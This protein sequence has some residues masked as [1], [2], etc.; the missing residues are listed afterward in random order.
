MLTEFRVVV[1][2]LSDVVHHGLRQ[3]R[4]WTRRGH[5]VPFVTDQSGLDE[6]TLV[7]SEVGEGILDHL[8][9]S[10]SAIVGR[11][12]GDDHGVDLPGQRGLTFDRVLVHRLRHT[13]IISEFLCN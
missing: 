7:G 4:P 3:L 8:A 12:H 10:P 5:R 11:I 1:V 6:L 9:A 13:I 2:R